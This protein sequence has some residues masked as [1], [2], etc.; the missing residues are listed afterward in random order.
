MQRIRTVARTLR[1]IRVFDQFGW[2]GR[3]APMD[4][5]PGDQGNASAR[6]PL[7]VAFS[8]PLLATTINVFQSRILGAALLRFAS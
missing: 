7:S 6:V 1:R 4:M 5:V 8:R 2:C 3:P